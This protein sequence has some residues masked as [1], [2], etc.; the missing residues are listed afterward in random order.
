MSLTFGSLD[1]D[2]SRSEIQEAALQSAWR[3]LRAVDSPLARGSR[4]NVV[5][6]IL[7]SHIN[8]SIRNGLSDVDRLRADALSFL[9]RVLPAPPD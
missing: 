9:H 6:R 7:S 4:S 3:L 2:S 1:P 5:R 8:K